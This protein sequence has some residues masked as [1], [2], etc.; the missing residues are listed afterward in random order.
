V[1]VLLD[2]CIPRKFKRAFPEHACWT[3]PEVGF[4]G[5][6]NGSPLSLAEGAAFEIFLTMDKGLHYRSD[7]AK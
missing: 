3:V 4:A 6:T 7:L 2:E 5:Q 1:K